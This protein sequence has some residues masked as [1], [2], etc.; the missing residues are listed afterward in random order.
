M[1]ANMGLT[2]QRRAFVKFQLVAV[3]IVGQALSASLIRSQSSPTDPK[4]D[5]QSLPSK[6]VSIKECENGIC[7]TWMFYGK[8]GHGKMPSGAEANLTVTNSDP[9]NIE[10]ERLDLSGE[11]AGTVLYYTGTLHSGSLGGEIWTKPGKQGEEKGHWTGTIEDTPEGLPRTIRSCAQH[12]LTLTWNKDHYDSLEDS[13]SNPGPTFKVDKFGPGENGVSIHRIQIGA[14][15]DYV[16]KFSGEGIILGTQY[17]RDDSGKTWNGPFRL[18]YGSAF[19]TNC[20]GTPPELRST[21]GQQP[22]IVVSPVVVCYPWFFGMV[23]GV[24]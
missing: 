1:L 8:Q 23:C 10:I 20:T 16:G 6:S 9:K 4:T 17:W 7:A 14:S 19:D 11:S 2:R 18:T 15:A 21:Q 3:L 12:N 13:H 22:T 5:G 24:P